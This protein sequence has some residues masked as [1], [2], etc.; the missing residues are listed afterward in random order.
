MMT[1]KALLREVTAVVLAGVA[2]MMA[3]AL[4]TFTARDPSFDHAIAHTRVANQ[5][6]I[7]G[8]YAADALYQ[9]LGYGGWLLVVLAGVL[10]LRMAMGRAP[11][12]GG[13]TALFW[14]PFMVGIAALMHAHGAGLSAWLPSLPAGPG[15]AI[16]RLFDGSLVRPL[17]AL[18]RD[19]LLVVLVL[20]SFVAA[21]HLSLL[22]MARQL[23]RGSGRLLA[24]VRQQLGRLRAI[25]SHRRERIE[26]REKRAEARGQRPVHIV[27][28]EA[29][30]VAEPAK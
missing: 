15:G 9:L 25:A 10:A 4:A 5:A 11:Y 27:E 29:P 13:W 12:L 2:A 22:G 26:G 1:P 7:V 21:S 24:V 6:G 28:K 23:L 8:A 16:G 30:P 17:H 20:S 14:L 3:L 19:I 18:G